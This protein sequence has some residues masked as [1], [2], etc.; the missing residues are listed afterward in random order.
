MSI[1]K[2]Q[3]IL[4]NLKSW[5]C[6]QVKSLGNKLTTVTG[7]KNQKEIK[8]AFGNFQHLRL[9][10]HRLTDLW[11]WLHCK[12]QTRGRCSP[13]AVGVS[14]GLLHPPATNHVSGSVRA[15]TS[16]IQHPQLSGCQQQYRAV[17]KD[18]ERTRQATE[19]QFLHHRQTQGQGSEVT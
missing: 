3:L 19:N 7:T 11:S 15:C 4:G 18:T 14:S 10:K 6:T 9:F 5:C 2:K 1:F 12:H 17:I 13:G 8:T 16:I